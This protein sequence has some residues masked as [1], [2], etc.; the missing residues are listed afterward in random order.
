M[1]HSLHLQ[2]FWGLLQNFLSL[3]FVSNF[4]FTIYLFILIV[5]FEKKKLPSIQNNEASL[6]LISLQNGSE[7]CLR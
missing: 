2:Q 3:I 7:I 4:I 1:R 6:P 5:E